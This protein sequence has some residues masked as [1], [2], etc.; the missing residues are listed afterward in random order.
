MLK[1]VLRSVALLGALALLATALPSLSPGPK[2][3]DPP[4]PTPPSVLLVTIDTLRADHVGCYGYHQVKTPTLDQL[5]AEGIRFDHAYAQVPITLPS[6][7]VILTGT[8]PMFNGVRDFTSPGLP[9][10]V[11]SLAE[12][13]R[14]GGYHTAAFVSSFVLNSMWGL[15]RGFEVYDDV[16]GADSNPGQTLF[17]LERRGDH[18]VDRMLDWLDHRSREPFF[19]WL[20]LY[21]PHSP[22]RP[23]EPYRSQYAS[24][25]YDGE[26]AFDDVQVGRV[27]ARLRELGLLDRTAIVLT[28]DHGESLGEHGEGEHG[29]FIYNATLRVPLIL[30]LPTGW[31]RRRTI[32]LPVGTVDIAPT[33]ARLCGISTSATR[34]FQGHSLFEAIEETASG[35]TEAVYGES[36]YPKDSF[37]WHELRAVVTSRFKYIDAPRPEL[38]DLERDPGE[39]SNLAQASSATAS[40]LRD[41]LMAF[42]GRFGRVQPP[43]ETSPMSPERQEKLRALGY[44]SYQARSVTITNAARAADPKD[45]IGTLNRILRTSDLMRA[46]KF[47][48]ADET[49]ASLEKAEPSLYVLPFQRGENS[50]AWGKPGA[51]VPEFRKAVSLN[52]SFDQAF[53]GLGRAYFQIGQD[54]KAAEALESALQLNPRNFLARVA[55]AKVYWRQNQLARAEAELAQVVRERPEFAEARG[56]YGIILAKRGRYR[57]A[58]PEIERGIQ[59]GDQDAVAYNYLGVTYAELGDS[60]K[61]VAAYEQAV[62][63]NP[64]YAAALMNLA[65]QYRKQGQTAK[66]RGYYQKVCEAS[67]EL[68]RQYAPQFSADSKR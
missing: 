22:Y 19:V 33:I 52:P 61:A 28:S 10:N 32:S 37:G 68:C 60:A 47:A 21:D 63:I 24:H 2:L 4:N 62:Q 40:S 5:A 42:E 23:P 50:L 30:K 15:S 7:A 16:A 31:P 11:P 48:E 56:D 64:R 43:P 39:R 67:Q 51:A 49:L 12:I 13:L 20:H 17:Q 8:Y 58:L 18:T 3:D 34:S 38:Y 57:E 35:G 29:F 44:L 1:S 59:S 6:H 54:D 25:P 41:R 14:R 53:L 27:V 36:Y 65:L 45:K 9:D 46:G 26:I 55:L 66:A